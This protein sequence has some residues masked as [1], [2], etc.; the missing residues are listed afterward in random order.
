VTK[1]VRRWPTGMPSLP[2][3]VIVAAIVG[4]V[5]LRFWGLA[6]DPVHPSWIGWQQ[7]EGRWTE[8][9]RAWALFGTLRG[10]TDVAALHLALSP[11][12]QLV[13]AAVFSCVGVGF[14]AARLPSAVA[15]AV[16]RGR[17]PAR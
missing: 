8:S 2:V 16:C 12:W 1:A 15:G 13:T 9:G 4:G 6:D 7:D 17:S 10:E 14:A 11:L 3:L 5:A